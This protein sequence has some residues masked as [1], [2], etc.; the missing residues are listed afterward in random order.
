M[1]VL[2]GG[3]QKYFAQRY[4]EISNQARNMDSWLRNDF[5]PTAMYLEMD[6]LEAM[7]ASLTEDPMVHLKMLA[8]S[9]GRIVY[10]IAWWIL[11]FQLFSLLY[12][13]YKRVFI[14][15]I[16]ICLYPFVCAMYV[17]D[18]MGDGKAQSMQNWF[19]E[20]LAN[21][22]VQLLH[23]CI[24]VILINMGIQI[25]QQDPSRNWIFLVMCT[26]FLFPAERLL[27][28]LVGLESSTLGTL[29]TNIV[30]SIVAA[31]TIATSAVNAGKAV[32]NTSVAAAN[33][34]KQFGQGMSEK[35]M[36]AA[37]Y[38]A[39]LV[40]E[41]MRKENARFH[42]AGDERRKKKQAINDSRNNVKQKR[43][44][45]DKK[46]KELNKED[47]SA[48][49]NLYAARGDIRDSIGEIKGK[50]TDKAKEAAQR[51]RE[52]I[53]NSSIGQAASAVK[54]GAQKVSNSKVGQFAKGAGAVAGKGLKTAGTAAKYAGQKLYNNRGKIAKTYGKFAQVAAG[55]VRAMDSLGSS[56]IGAGLSDFG[57][58][59]SGVVEK[60][61]LN[62]DLPNMEQ[63][64]EKISSRRSSGS[65]NSNSSVATGIRDRLANSSRSSSTTSGG[66]STSTAS[67]VRASS[68]SSGS[69]GG[70]PTITP[71]SLGNLTRTTR[72]EVNVKDPKVTI[73]KDSLNNTKPRN[74]NPIK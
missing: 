31:K 45:L 56:G 65:S 18:K 67:R 21:C 9:E 42:E 57:Q 66:S 24:Y 22:L 68:S 64:S 71:S 74:D 4:R 53:Q 33:A 34:A 13:Y 11:L 16:L 8:K 17:V 46:A 32:A 60:Q 20:F 37:Q 27:R 59:T 70:S 10:A 28:S 73:T 51:A 43:I 72:T 50:A 15:I 54:S 36:N 7:Q 2:F 48:K 47:R 23:A 30:G 58:I 38:A 40:R 52:G 12:M 25:C 63:L 44:E 6:K 62:L 55:G 61:K 26:A 1:I 49:E 35:G 5:A 39:F 19:K 29:K 69:A 3:R 41:D 14:I